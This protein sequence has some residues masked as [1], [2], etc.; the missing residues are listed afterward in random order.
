MSQSTSLSKSKI[1]IV[2]LEGIH[3][4]AIRTLEQA[5]YT[6][7]HHFPGALADEELEAQLADAHFVGIRSRTRLPQAVLAAASKLAGIGCFCIGTDQV[8]LQAAVRRGIPVF[9]APFSNTRSVAE[10]VLAEAI[11]L[12]RQVP[13]KSRQAHLGRW[14]KSASGSNE[15]RGKT[16]GIIGYG[17]I[18]TQLS[19][20]A[21]AWGMKVIFTDVVSR[22][23]L[24][25]AA[26]VPL[27]E[28]LQ[29]ADVISLHVPRSTETVRLLGA[30]E[31]KWVQPGSVL[32]NASR[33]NV[34]DIDAL[35]DVLRA[36]RLRG[37]AVDVFPSEPTSADEPF[38]SPL[39]GLD[40]VILTPHIGGSTVEAQ[41]NIGVE[42]AEKLIL[43]SDTG[44]TVGSVNFPQ[45]TLPRQDGRHRLLHIHRNQPGVLA[46][47]NQV[48]SEN[49]INIEG[50]YLRTNEQI[51]YVIFDVES[52]E[53]QL[54]R[55][56]L[57]QID[58]TIRTRVL[59]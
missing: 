10:L 57:K 42:V 29:T 35:A 44:A 40:N 4:S 22:L 17:N 30:R 18:G 24:G 51:G 16:L 52:G 56:K 21:E 7:I 28:L 12:M 2:L 38:V 9:N 41:H 26:Q 43:F 59:W 47:I 8:D 1:K 58:G 3:E 46:A 11:L 32:V 48:F 37:A 13:H 49:G 14:L 55:E 15:I 20:L 45:V 54:A 36:G 25:N 31:L 6:Q 53:S 33:G 34:I 19:V 27:W 39:Q 23:P 50:Q 5:G